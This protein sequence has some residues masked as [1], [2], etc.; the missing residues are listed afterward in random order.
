MIAPP[1]MATW[2]A[3]ADFVAMAHSIKKS[4][5]MLSKLS[6]AFD[7][8][9]S[10]TPRQDGGSEY[11]LVCQA[12]APS[13]AEGSWS[14]TLET[15]DG[16]HVLSADDTDLGDLNRL[17]LLAAVRGLE[18]IDGPAS[19]MLL[20]TN[21]YLIRSL[22]ESLPRWRENQFVWEHFGR[23]IDVQHADLWRR[24]DRALSIHRVQ[25]CLISSRLV[26]SGE[27]P[28]AN[29]SERWQRVDGAH[30]DMPRPHHAATRSSSTGSSSIGSSSTVS[31]GKEV[32]K[33]G[34][35]P[36]SHALFPAAAQDKSKD[37]LRRW[38]LA[39]G[40]SQ[41]SR[42]PRHRFSAADLLESA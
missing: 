13:I 41:E 30:S 32:A 7:A 17:T 4:E 26:S 37:G 9:A 2:S 22:A 33:T 23:R 29:S 10:A 31:A 15:A 21:R 19:V 38:L 18:S 8:T 24:I 27:N 35:W 25:A 39:G 5:V 36:T 42:A 11:L 16:Q 28:L 6:S 3:Y 40:A 1:V 12:S 34:D 20:S 14:F